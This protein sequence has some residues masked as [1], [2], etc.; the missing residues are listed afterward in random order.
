[1]PKL[2][3]PAAIA[4]YKRDGFYCPVRVMPAA[5]ARQYRAALEAG[6][7]LALIHLYR[8]LLTAREQIVLMKRVDVR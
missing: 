3:T 7:G 1:M 8:D 6:H 5:Q 4:A 2:L